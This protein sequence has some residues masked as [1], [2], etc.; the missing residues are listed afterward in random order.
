VLVGFVELA[1]AELLRAGGI[2]GVLLIGVGEPSLAEPIA[3]V[4]VAGM[5][6]TV[7][8]LA[9]VAAPTLTTVP[10]LRLPPALPSHYDDQASKVLHLQPANLR[11]VAHLRL[12]GKLSPISHRGDSMRPELLA[13]E[14]SDLA[15]EVVQ[16]HCARGGD[17]VVPV[18]NVV[19]TVPLVQVD[20]WKGLAAAHSDKHPLEPVAGALARRP[21]LPV[22]DLV[23]PANGTDD[24]PQRNDPL[25]ER[26]LSESGKR[27]RLVYAWQVETSRSAYKQ[28]RKV[29]PLMLGECPIERAFGVNPRVR[30]NGTV[31]PSRRRHAHH[32]SGKPGSGNQHRDKQSVHEQVQQHRGPPPLPLSPGRTP[33]SPGHSPLTTARR[34]QA[35]AVLLRGSPRLVA[36]MAAGGCGRQPSRR[37]VIPLPP[38]PPSAISRRRTQQTRPTT[39]RARGRRRPMIG[40]LVAVTVAVIRA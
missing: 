21:E 33:G 30:G 38:T 27:H 3:L 2:H 40:D 35:T 7:A 28:R 9:I 25:A 18:G 10:W 16:A 31:R 22:E 29:P 24:V 8:G 17:T 26:V 12:Y 15:S 5:V 23:R 11:L 19:V 13:H 20:R 39:Q 1:T 6:L 32:P 37:G 14:V 36:I 34:D 4:S